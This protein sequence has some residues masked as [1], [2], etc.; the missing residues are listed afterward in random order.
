MAVPGCPLRM[1][2][3]RLRAAGGGA[4]SPTTRRVQS[5][6][7]WDMLGGNIEAASMSR[8]IIS[9][10]SVAG[11]RVAMIFGFTHGVGPDWE[12]AH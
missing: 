2:M 6:V 1:P 10:E 7:A 4:E 3:Q 8:A 5:W 9:A 12:P 11:P